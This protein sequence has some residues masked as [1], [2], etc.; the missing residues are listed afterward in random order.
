M[1]KGHDNKMVCSIKLFNKQIATGSYDN[2][3]KIWDLSKCIDIKTINETG[4]I[5][6][7]LEF[8]NNMLLS[9]QVI[10]I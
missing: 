1:F 3:I 7:L 6:F 5:L 2:K 4:N 9:G 10:I 8:E